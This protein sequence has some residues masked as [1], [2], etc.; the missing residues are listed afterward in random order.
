MHPKLDNFDKL[1][2]TYRQL[3]GE[4]I[5]NARSAANPK[6]SQEQLS[7]YLDISRSHLSKIENGVN[8]P[9]IDIL[10]KLHII[11]DYSF[12]FFMSEQDFPHEKKYTSVMNYLENQ[13]EKKRREEEKKA[14][15]EELELGPEDLE[16]IFDVI[17]K[18]ARKLPIK[19]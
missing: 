18:K 5:K 7:G 8:F 4:R 1:K 6:I 2:I 13:N 17:M 9:S 15:F 14:M 19:K 12:D 11:F 10:I 16:Q 3:I